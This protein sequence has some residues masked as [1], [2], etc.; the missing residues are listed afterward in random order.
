MNAQRKLSAALYLLARRRFHILECEALAKE[1]GNGSFDL[2]GPTGRFRCRW[3]DPHYGIFEKLDDPHGKAF[4]F[5][6]DIHCE[7]LE[8][9]Q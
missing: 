9:F 8:G 4:Q 2:V 6:A 1:L 7:N 3:V 5:I